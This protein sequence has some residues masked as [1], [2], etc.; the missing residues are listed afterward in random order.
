MSIDTDAP[1]PDL[2]AGNPYL[3]GAWEPVRDELDADELEIIGELP[4]ALDGVYLRNGANP[5]FA[6]VTR[7]HLF[8]GDGM[9][10]GVDAARR[11]SPLSQ[12]LRRQQGPALRATRRPRRCSAGSASS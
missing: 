12:P 6:P 9:V 7:Y 8:D 1:M 11:S 10:H 2:N 4:A 5:A 3:T